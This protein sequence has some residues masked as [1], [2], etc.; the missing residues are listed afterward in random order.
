[1]DFRGGRETSPSS[2]SSRVSAARRE[3][4]GTPVHSEDYAFFGAMLSFTFA[5]SGKFLV[6]I[7]KSPL[8]RIPSKALPAQR[9]SRPGAPS[10]AFFF[11]TITQN[12]GAPPFAVFE[13][14]ARGTL[15]LNAVE[16]PESS[17]AASRSASLSPLRR[18]HTLDDN[19]FAPLI[20]DIRV[21]HPSQKQGRVGHP[22]SG[23]FRRSQGRCTLPTLRQNP[24]KGWATRPLTCLLAAPVRTTSPSCWGTRSRRWRSTTR[25]S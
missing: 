8:N 7:A 6:C 16:L 5:P 11:C 4:W 9:F 3:T 1:M 20:S 12:V 22:H 17:A 14:W 24:A 10:F 23:L 18:K 15:T 13:G 2:W 19:E 25:N 21:S